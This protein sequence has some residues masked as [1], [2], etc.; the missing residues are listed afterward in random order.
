[1]HS[2]LQIFNNICVVLL[3]SMLM[4]PVFPDP[5]AFIQFVI[6]MYIY[7][8]KSLVMYPYVHTYLRTYIYNT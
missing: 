8:L 6:T 3:N 1:M 7:W 2:L 5:I 4:C